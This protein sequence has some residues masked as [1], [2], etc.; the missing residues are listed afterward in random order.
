MAT[1]DDRVDPP[2]GP[3]AGERYAYVIDDEREVR[4]SL[5]FLLKTFGITSRPFSAA[6]DF[7]AE[8]PLLR[9]G[10]VIV[11]VRM[12]GQD[13]ISML[14]QMETIGVSWPTIVITGHAEVATAVRAMKRGAIEFLGKPFDDEDLL[15]ALERGFKDL[16]RDEAEHEL[17]RK[18]KLKI[19][20]LTPRERLVL[21]AL[22][23]GL[24]NKQMAARF[25]LSP[26]TVEM[27]R[28]NML[29]RAEATSLPQLISIAYTAGVRLSG[30]GGSEP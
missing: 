14:T 28:T 15:A 5:S 26:R 27:H 4:V 21:Q 19:D 18:A 29:R 22:M 16:S 25:G 10:C 24:S 17:A 23:E 12:P 9:P 11:D 8:L 20:R 13:G 2:A 3:G 6:E 1:D 30:D 7:L